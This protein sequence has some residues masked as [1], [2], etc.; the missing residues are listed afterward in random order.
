MLSPRAS[1][2]LTRRLEARPPGFDIAK[3]YRQ[4]FDAAKHDDEL[5]VMSKFTQRFPSPTRGTNPL[6]KSP[7][8]TSCTME[9][10]SKEK[11]RDSRGYILPFAPPPLTKEE[12]RNQLLQED[13]H[14]KNVSSPLGQ[15][16]LKMKDSPVPHHGGRS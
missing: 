14:G 6:L 13:K 8:G 1:P 3:T 11:L 7:R 10:A 16:Y 2:L 9:S 4:L 5:I 12:R 15:A